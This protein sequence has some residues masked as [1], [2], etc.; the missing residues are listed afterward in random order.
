MGKTAMMERPD[1]K[2]EQRRQAVLIKARKVVLIKIFALKGINVSQ[3]GIPRKERDEAAIDAQHVIEA[4]KRG[5]DF[6]AYRPKG[7]TGYC[8]IRKGQYRGVRIANLLGQLRAL[9]LYHIESNWQQV[10]GKGQV[11][12]VTF[13]TEGEGVPIP[14]PV[15][16]LL[17]RRFHDVTVW[18]NLKYDSTDPAKGQFRLD[19]INL[20]FPHIQEGD[21]WELVIPE[22]HPNTYRCI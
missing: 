8:L 21:S 12:F 17:L 2:E 14:E 13:S 11:I 19:T 18:C 20:A 5:L 6:T 4:A 9:G 1:R 15:E 10:E 7:D 3:L 16:A 22:A